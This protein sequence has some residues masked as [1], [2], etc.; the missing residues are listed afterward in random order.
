[1]IRPVEMQM[2]LPRTE[3][4]GNAQQYENQ[5]VVNENTFAAKEVAKEVK[6]NSETVIRKEGNELTDFKYD[7][8]DEG[9]G[10]YQNPR[11]RKKRQEKRDGEFDENELTKELIEENKQPRVNI[12][13]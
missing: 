2:L 11:K 7:A 1:M 13:I 9:K 4:V 12:Q 8:K 3:S 5:R 10:T 6:H